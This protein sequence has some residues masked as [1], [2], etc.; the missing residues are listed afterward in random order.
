MPFFGLS[1][2]ENNLSSQMM[3]LTVTYSANRLYTNVNINWPIG[4]SA[5]MRDKKL[6]S[7][8]PKPVTMVTIF[9]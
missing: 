4:D 3:L 5:F 1:F 6:S 2:R 9:S 8:S 7:M